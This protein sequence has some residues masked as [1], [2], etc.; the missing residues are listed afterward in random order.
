MCGH[1]SLRPPSSVLRKSSA[2]QPDHYHAER[3]AEDPDDAEQML[4]RFQD[5]QHRPL[6]RARKR[7]EHQPLDDE[8][9]ADR[10]Q[11]I[12]HGRTGSRRYFAAL[13]APAVL[14]FGPS[15]LLPPRSA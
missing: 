12:G 9:Q 14:V 8:D 6:R 7:R 2:Y 15:L 4:G 3:R 10:D 11:E 13:P 1:L 5:A